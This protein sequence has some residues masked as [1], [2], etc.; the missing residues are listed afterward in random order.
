MEKVL[1]ECLEAIE[2]GRLT[3]EECQQLYPK[4]REQ[5]RRLL[6]LATALR[7]APKV[8]PSRSFQRHARQRLLAKLPPQKSTQQKI[9]NV[10]S[11]SNIFRLPDFQVLKPAFQLLVILITVIAMG[12]GVTAVYASGETLPGDTFY[13][14]KTAIEELQLLITFDIADG[15][16]L[17]LEFVQRRIGEMKSLAELERYDD[18]AVAAQD[19]QSRLLDLNESLRKMALEGNARID[20]IGELVEDTLFYDTLILTGLVETVPAQTQGVLEVAVGASKSGNAIARQWV[21]LA[22]SSASTLP[23]ELPETQPDEYPGIPLPTGLACWPADLESDPPEGISLCEEDQTPV[24]LPDDLVLFCWPP[25]IPFAPPQDIPLCGEGETPLPANLGLICWP[26]QVSSTPPPGLSLCQEGQLPVPLP[27]NQG[28]LCWPSNT[29]F[30]PPPGI[31]LCEEGPYPTPAPEQLPCWPPELSRVPPPGMRLC[32]PGEWI[33]PDFKP[34]NVDGIQGGVRNLI[35][36]IFSQLTT[37]Y[38]WPS[39]LAQD[40]PPGMP[41]CPVK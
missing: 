25:E 38:C 11:L 7:E 29:P 22:T 37:N 35:Q 13:P 6:P 34:P 26:P 12:S 9:F 16:L 28:M 5:F 23:T 31:P 30:N 27:P 39:D 8:T 33:F 36:D 17:K 1:A 19:Y 40:P 2:E 18:I 3:L 32:E 15:A 4:Y 10:Q 20:E 41:V 21:Q 24:A 14:I